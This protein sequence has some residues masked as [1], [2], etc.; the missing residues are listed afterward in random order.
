M[1]SMVYKRIVLFIVFSRELAFDV[2]TRT[3]LSALEKE[4]CCH[5]GRRFS[6]N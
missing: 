1:A 6:T 4:R 5:S 3:P 2:A